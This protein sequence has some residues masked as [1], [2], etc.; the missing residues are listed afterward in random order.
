M[1]FVPRQHGANTPG[2][3]Q[4]DAASE[5]GALKEPG[6]AAVV[7]QRHIPEDVDRW[8]CALNPDRLPAGRV[9]LHP[10]AVAEVVDELCDLAQT[11]T[12]P[13]RD[14]LQADIADL[15]ATFTELTEAPY[16]RLRLDVVTTNMCRKFHIDAI[17]ARLVCTYRGT[18]TQYGIARDGEDPDE[19]LTVPTGAPFLMRGTR[20]P[21]TPAIGLKH[22]SPPIEGTGETRLMLVLDP[23]T[24]PYDEI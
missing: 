22:R 1:N 6:C 18:G 9:I 21:V 8:L 24:E 15:A 3:S 2:V 7:W 16:L 17:T 12:G 19:V 13:A 11:P 4:I 10:S 14:W 23:V 5:F 20:W